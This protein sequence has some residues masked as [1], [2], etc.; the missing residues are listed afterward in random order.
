MHTQASF[1]EEDEEAFASSTMIVLKKV[2][3]CESIYT[4]VYV[5]ICIYIYIL[6]LRSHYLLWLCWKRYCPW[7]YLYVCVCTYMHLHIYLTS[8]KKIGRRSHYL[9]WLC[10]KRYMYVNLF[11]RVCMYIHVFTH[12]PYFCKKDAEAF[13]SST[14]IVL[15]KVNELFHTHGN[16]SCQ[17]YTN[18]SCH[19]FPYEGICGCIFVYVCIFVCMYIYVFIYIYALLL[20]GSPIC[21]TWL[22]LTCVAWHIRHICYVYIKNCTSYGN[23][24]HDSFSCDRLRLIPICV[25]WHIPI[26][27][28]KRI[29]ICVT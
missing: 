1:C 16:E 6:L 10:W 25:T 5:H 9:L 3:V 12:T 21:V 15:K 28:T 22:V 20:R 8:A 14:M 17:R 4:C 11:I 26:C 24:W 23:Q 19:W 18:E 7:T 29:P 13:A 27:V 2:Y